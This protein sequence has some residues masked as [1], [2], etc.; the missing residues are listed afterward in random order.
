[1]GARW[2]LVVPAC[3][4]RARG[5]VKFALAHTHLRTL[6]A[7][8][9]CRPCESRDPYSAASRFVTVADSFCSKKRLWLWVPAFA[10]TTN[11][12]HTS[13]FSRRECAR[14]VQEFSALHKKG[15]G[16]AGCAMHPQ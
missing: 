6:A 15:V 11:V 9:R 14:V 1:M 2:L 16:N 7:N 10:G 5:Q 13:A 4:T 8:L 12:R 3:A